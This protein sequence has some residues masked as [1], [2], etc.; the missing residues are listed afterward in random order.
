MAT[1]GPSVVGS[2]SDP[3]AGL[4][5]DERGGTVSLA[6]GVFEGGTISLHEP[7]GWKRLPVTFVE[8]SFLRVKDFVPGAMRTPNLWTTA[9]LRLLIKTLR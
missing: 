4:T 6:G 1:S 8:T 2:R 5:G 3:P 7:V 9:I